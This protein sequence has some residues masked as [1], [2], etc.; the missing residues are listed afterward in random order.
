[1]V[2]NRQGGNSCTYL[3]RNKEKHPLAYV[4]CWEVN[5]ILYYGI[6]EPEGLRWAFELDIEEREIELG[7][8]LAKGVTEGDAGNNTKYVHLV[9]I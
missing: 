9:T 2:F 8:T 3:I 7:V 6:A 5:N 4:S 1:M